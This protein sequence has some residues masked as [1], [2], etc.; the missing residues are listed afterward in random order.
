MND[1][2]IQATTDEQQIA[3]LTDQVGRQ[4]K[5]KVE[6][7][8]TIEAYQKN[9]STALETMIDEKDLVDILTEKNNPQVPLVSERLAEQT[10]VHDDM[11]V[12]IAGLKTKQ[13]HVAD[14]LQVHVRALTTLN[15]QK[16]NF[17]THIFG[18]KEKVKVDKDDAS[19]FHMDEQGHMEATIATDLIKW[20]DS[21]QMTLTRKES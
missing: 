11:V 20:R 19:V 9:A 14:E 16:G 18:I 8:K 15:V 1:V 10:V 13:S 7:G 17:S 2:R 12:Y 6:M 3:F 21:S 4:I 5:Q